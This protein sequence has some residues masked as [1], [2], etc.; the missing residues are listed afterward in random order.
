MRRET[1]RSLRQRDITHQVLLHGKPLLPRPGR[2]LVHEPK[3]GGDLVHP[4]ARGAGGFIQLIHV[5]RAPA[6][7][8]GLEKKVEGAPLPPLDDYIIT[9]CEQQPRIKTQFI[10]S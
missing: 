10:S 3:G 7:F 9:E 2:N 6:L 4:A 8:G 1:A 5:E